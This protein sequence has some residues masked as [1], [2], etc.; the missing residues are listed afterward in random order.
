MP[1]IPAPRFTIDERTILQA[2]AYS[3]TIG[4]SYGRASG[5]S[6]ALRRSP[7]GGVSGSVANDF[8]YSLTASATAADF[9]FVTGT[10]GSYTATLAG[11]VGNVAITVRASG[12]YTF[13]SAAD[14]G[15]NATLNLQTSGFQGIVRASAS[16]AVVANATEQALGAALPAAGVSLT[17]ISG[18][19]D[20]LAHAFSFAVETDGSDSTFTLSD[21]YGG[22]AVVTGTLGSRTLNFTVVGGVNSCA[23]LQLTLAGNSLV[24]NAEGTLKY[25]AI[26]N[27]TAPDQALFDVRAA[28]TGQTGT[29]HTAQVTDGNDSNNLT[30]QLNETN[31]TQVTVISQNVQIDGQGLAVD[32]SQNNWSDRSNIDSAA[33]SIEGAKLRLRRGLL[34]QQ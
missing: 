13:S 20:N 21:G 10:F 16:T 2:A 8:S 30:V 17:S 27:F 24:A 34:A 29:I 1:S 7:T 4:T 11:P 22:I 18:V 14:A 28:D 23:T 26:G 31:T 3:A 32:V 6:P 25:N 12:S 5:P 19:A 33:A 15:R 9:N